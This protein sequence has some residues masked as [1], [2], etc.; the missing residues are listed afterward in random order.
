MSDQPLVLGVNSVYHESSAC[1]VRGSQ[2]L[3]I[4]EEERFNRRKHAKPAGVDTADQ[5]PTHAIEYCLR[6]AGIT[7]R[8]L[9]SIAL[10]FDLQRR[11][12]PITERVTPGSWG[13]PEG[14]RIF[15]AGVARIPERLA[16]VLGDDVGEKIHW[17]HHELAHAASTYYASPYSDAAV[18]SLDGIGEWTTGLLAHGRDHK[19]DEIRLLHYPNSIGFLW[20]KFAKFVGLGEY[21]AAK[22]MA[23]AAF[24]EPGSFGPAMKRLF[25]QDSSELDVDLDALRFRVEDYGP[26]EELF[27]PRRRPGEYIDHRDA[28][29]AAALQQTTEE[30]LLELAD[31]LFHATG[32]NNLCLAGGVALNCIANGRLARDSRF[33]NIFV[34]PLAHDGGTALGAALHTVHQCHDITDRWEMTSPYLGP[35][36]TE[37]DCVRALEEADLEYTRLDDAPREVATLLAQ[38][39]IGGW[40]DGAAEV[41]PR[42]LGHRSILADPRRPGSREIINLRVKHREYFRPFAPSVL[43]EHAAEWFDIHANS[44]SYRFMSFGLSVQA[45]K[46]PLIPAVLHVDGTSRL[47]SVTAETNPRYH[48]LISAFHEMTGVPMVLNTSFNTYD[49]PIVL[50]P[51]DA[52]RT[53]RRTGLDFLVLGDF[54]VRTTDGATPS[55]RLSDGDRD[56]SPIG[57]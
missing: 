41:G 29:V 3:A 56:S 7:A 47:Q 20:E 13:D 18:L 2:V 44:P 42:A 25:H 50:T 54:L 23:L 32:S 33:D 35:S 1:L 34:Q 19:I 45:D 38:G 22:V 21:E 16:A 57:D 52:I 46:Q 10:S 51:G 24:A 39:L 53:F 28:Q 11:P 49:E 55:R 26:L 48:A 14:E 43:E 17:V 30:V 9:D 5:L 37:Q 15:R 6:T 40:F 31:E 8:D 27:G 4:G 12:E 36:Y